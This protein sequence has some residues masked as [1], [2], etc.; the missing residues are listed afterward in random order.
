MSPQSPRGQLLLSPRTREEFR[1]F[2][3]L[4]GL[5]DFLVVECAQ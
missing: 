5:S 4:E 3:L 2:R 1:E